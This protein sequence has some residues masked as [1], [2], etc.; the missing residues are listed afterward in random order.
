M[1]ENR[2]LWQHFS[3]I[4][5]VWCGMTSGQSTLK[6]SRVWWQL[7]FW[8]RHA[9]DNLLSKVKPCRITFKLLWTLPILVYDYIVSVAAHIWFPHGLHKTR[10]EIDLIYL[11]QGIMGHTLVWPACNATYTVRPCRL[12]SQG[13]VTRLETNYWKEKRRSAIQQW[14]RMLQL[15]RVRHRRSLKG[16]KELV[17][18]QT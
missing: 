4:Q 16:G 1:P 10:M 18:I 13:K 7:F 8:C 6:K 5:P 15:W 12:C 2:G 3:C 9:G 14:G 11:I 17:H